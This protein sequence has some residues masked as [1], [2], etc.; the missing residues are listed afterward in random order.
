MKPIASRTGMNRPSGQSHSRRS[1]KPG[2]AIE[3]T[4][5]S[6][7]VTGWSRSPRRWRISVLAGPDVRIHP[8]LPYEEGIE[9]PW[10]PRVQAG[11]CSEVHYHNLGYDPERS[12]PFAGLT[13]LHYNFAIPEYD[14]QT[15]A[16]TLGKPWRRIT[17]EAPLIVGER[18]IRTRRFPLESAA[19]VKLESGDTDVSSIIADADLEQGFLYLS[20]SIT[21]YPSLSVSSVYEERSLVYTGVNLNTTWNPDILG[22]FVGVYVIPEEVSYIFGP[23]TRTVY[24]VIRETAEEIETALDVL[25]FDNGVLVRPILVGIYQVIPTEDREAVV[26][27]D[28]PPKGGG[29]DETFTVNLTN[30]DSATISDPQGVGTITDDDTGEREG[31]REEPL[32]EAEE[33]GDA[34]KARGHRGAV[35]GGRSP[36]GGRTHPAC[37][38]PARSTGTGR[39]VRGPVPPPT[40][41]ARR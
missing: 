2:S 14:N 36:R 4:A 29:L 6:S 39:P 30:P 11:R 7:G 17:A 10:Y 27:L 15:F 12:G 41:S 21:K 20:E 19:A 34:D 16:R 24:H 26:W 33:R 38:R 35:S 8:L 23:E 40:A 22:K 1:R 32:S 18:I 9:K 31:A 25:A 37:C 28:S 3:R 13:R 5:P